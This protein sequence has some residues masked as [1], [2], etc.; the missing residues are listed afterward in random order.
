MLPIFETNDYEGIPVLL[1]QATWLVKAGDGEPGSHPEVREYVDDI[2]AAVESPDLVFRSTRDERS[3]IFYRLGV[4]RGDFVGRHL[5]VVVK[6]VSE[7][8]GLRGYVSTM[9]LTRSVYSRGALLWAKP[10]QTSS[11]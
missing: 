11:H 9:Y 7:P 5:A 2:R 1:T 4:G 10:P 6:Y 8:T 3:R